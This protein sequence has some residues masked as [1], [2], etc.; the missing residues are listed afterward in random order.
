MTVKKENRKPYAFLTK[1][2]A[3][4]LIKRD[5]CLCIYEDSN[6]KAIKMYKPTICRRSKKCK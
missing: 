2:S 3:H 4:D 1:Q 6:P 5:P